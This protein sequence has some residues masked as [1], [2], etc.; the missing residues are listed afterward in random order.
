MGRPQKF[1][2]LDVVERAM[3]LFWERGFNEASMTA[4]L[5]TMDI[6]PGSFYR[7]FGSKEELLL[8]CMEH[9]SAMA[10]QCC[11]TIVA[12]SDSEREVI[13]AVFQFIINEM[14]QHET[15][16]G[17]LLVNIFLELSTVHHVIGTRAR[18]LLE[19][20][21]EFIRSRLQIAQTSGELTSD[22]SVDDLTTFLFGTFYALRVMGKAGASRQE[23]D[24]VCHHSIGHV[25]GEAAG[26]KRTKK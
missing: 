11:T 20:T 3:H 21:R 23:L 15:R 12:E 1:E 22:E 2:R 4:L 5:Q 18:E 24:V 10:G 16:R 14:A 25:F 7:I 17:C 6:R 19:Q 8:A 26:K 9:Y 13:T